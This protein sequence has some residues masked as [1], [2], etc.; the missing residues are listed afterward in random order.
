LENTELIKRCQRGDLDSFSELYKLYNKKA[1]G[2]AYLISNN[3][4]IVDDIVQETFIQ[5]FLNIKKLKSPETFEVWFYKILLRTGWRMVKKQNR[6]ISI[7]DGDIEDLSEA[8][9]YNSEIHG[10]ETR[11]VVKIALEKLSLPLK[12]VVIL[13]YFN[14]MTIQ[15]ISKVIGCFNGTVKSRLHNAKKKLYCELNE[16]FNDNMQI[17]RPITVY[18]RKESSI[19]GEQ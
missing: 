9:G 3:K 13:H 17:D 1:L 11:M 18:K 14:D 6:V 8:S 19:D 12:T 16:M 4:G 10:S 7:D 2:T 5:C 15:Q